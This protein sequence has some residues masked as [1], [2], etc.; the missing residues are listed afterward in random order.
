MVL[1]LC[2]KKKFCKKLNVILI[3]VSKNLF[4]FDGF[5]VIMKV[6]YLCLIL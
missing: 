6:C 4:V 5:I 3:V 2:L 1:L